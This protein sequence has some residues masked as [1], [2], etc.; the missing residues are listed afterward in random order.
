[1][2]IQRVSTVNSRALESALLLAYGDTNA[3][4]DE[5]LVR[6]F[7]LAA[8]GFHSFDV[9]PGYQRLLNTSLSIPFDHTMA[10]LDYSFGLIEEYSLNINN[11]LRILFDLRFEMRTA[12]G[13]PEDTRYW[14]FDLADDDARRF[15]EFRSLL[16][17]NDVYAASIDDA[18]AIRNLLRSKSGKKMM[19]QLVNL[20]HQ[21]GTLY[22]HLRGWNRRVVDTIRNTK[23]DIPLPIGVME[24]S[25]AATPV[26]W[27]GGVAMR[28]DA[29]DPNVWQL[30][31]ELRDGELKFRADGSF[32]SNWG[33]P[34]RP[35][36]RAANVG[37]EFGGNPDDVFPRGVAAFGG[38]NIPVKAGIY[39]VTFNSQ[40]FEYF[41]ERVDSA[42][43]TDD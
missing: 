12:A 9:Q 4:P 36:N 13:L 40:S 25:G 24:L 21:L 28:R 23:S 22:I 10:E 19:L 15:D 31:I 43:E 38:L 5:E 39:D 8:W 34:N 16:F 41:F 3:I 37:F 2:L 42:G 32:A 29:E 17:N 26:D 18:A 7:D 20:H 35:E 27:S 14:G 1:M 6:H 30:R 11:L 33:A